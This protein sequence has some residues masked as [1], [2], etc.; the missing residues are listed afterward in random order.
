MAEASQSRE[1]YVRQKL[2]GAKVLAHSDELRA[3]VDEIQ[4]TFS[5][6]RCPRTAIDGGSSNR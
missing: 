3:S 1:T 6:W 5:R 4:L 2:E